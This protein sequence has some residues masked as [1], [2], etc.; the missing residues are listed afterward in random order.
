[1]ACVPVSCVGLLANLT[2]IQAE[3]YQMELGLSVRE[4]PLWVVPYSTIAQDY[5]DLLEDFDAYAQVQ[6]QD[7]DTMLPSSHGPVNC[8]LHCDTT[9][10]NL[11]RQLK[12]SCGI[13]ASLQSFSDYTLLSFLMCVLEVSLLLIDSLTPKSTTAPATTWK[14]SSLCNCCTPCLSNGHFSME[15]GRW[16][17]AAKAYDSL[18]LQVAES[19]LTTV[20]KNFKTII[21]QEAGSSSGSVTSLTDKSSTSTSVVLVVTPGCGR[22]DSGYARLEFVISAEN[23]TKE[24]AG[25]E[26]RRKLQSTPCS[27]TDGATVSP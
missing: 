10:G 13:S 5:T 2:C 27:A 7:L 3:L 21:A 1:M 24:E 17:A 26:A 8:E 20:Y 14:G 19:L 12:V 18:C 23:I 11:H 25:V 22:D 16:K 6:L 4:N 9:C 15:T